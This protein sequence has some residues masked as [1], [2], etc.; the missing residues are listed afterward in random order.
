MDD[1]PTPQRDRIDLDL[2]LVEVTLTEVITEIA[3]KAPPM[4]RC[5]IVRG[6]FRTAVRNTDGC[7]TAA[8]DLSDAALEAIFGKSEGVQVFETP[9]VG[10]PSRAAD[11]DAAGATR[12]SQA[13]DA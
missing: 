8:V 2:S 4:N 10:P 3:V 1:T 13:R 12:P 11:G 6:P 5:Y 9:E 7:Y